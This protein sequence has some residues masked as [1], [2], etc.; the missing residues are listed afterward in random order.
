MR[1]EVEITH[2]KTNSKTVRRKLGL[3]FG[4]PSAL[5]EHRNSNVDG[6]VLPTAKID[7]NKVITCRITHLTINTVSTKINL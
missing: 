3:D 5:V 1:D 4:K 7:F 2:Y 6:K